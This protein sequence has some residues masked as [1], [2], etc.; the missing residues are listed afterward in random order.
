MSVRDET[1]TMAINEQELRIVSA[2]DELILTLDPIQGLWTE[3]QYIRLTDHSHRLIEFTDGSIEVLPMPTDR[4]QVIS[5]FL[6]FAFHAYVRQR[7]GTVLYAP[8]RL[9]IR[10]GKYREPDLLL[11]RDASDPRRQNAYWL[12]ADL[13]VEIVSLDDPERDTIRKRSDYAEAAIPEY[14]IV[15]PAGESITVLRLDNERYVQHGV[16]QRGEQ[17]SSV[18]LDRFTVDVNAVFDAE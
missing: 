6:L 14:W 2:D 18:L 11:I 12:G 4:H 16:F 5:L 8:L 7:G 3:E 9:Q 15:D 13:V 10:P 17:A 1:T